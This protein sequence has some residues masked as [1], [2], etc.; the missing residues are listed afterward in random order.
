MKRLVSFNYILKTFN[1]LKKINYFVQV[2]A[3][4]GE[5]HDPLNSLLLKNKWNGILIEPQKDMLKKYK[6][7]YKDRDNLIFINAAVHPTES[8]IDL[9]KIKSPDEYSHTGWA[10]IMPKRFKDTIYEKDLI[11][12]KVRAIPLMNIIH[13]SGFKHIDLLQIDTE[14]YDLDVLKMFDLNIFHPLL[15][16][17]EHYHLSKK[18]YEE[19]VDYL[20]NYGYVCFKKG[21]DTISIKKDSININFII[22]Y[23]LYRVTASI[24]SRYFNNY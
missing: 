11:I 15:I 21:Y 24:K 17:F 4:D 1:Y 16:Q 7:R 6:N 5:M 2:G 9:Y 18:Q 23:I 13:N 12:E 22:I 14:G 8:S 3:H 19:S 20:K 10:S